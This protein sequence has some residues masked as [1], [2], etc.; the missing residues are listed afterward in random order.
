[1][2][3]HPAP[4]EAELWER[5]RRKQVGFKF[6]RQAILRHWIVDFW[7]PAKRLIVEVDGTSHLDPV[8]QFFDNFRDWCFEA[9]ANITTLRFPAEH[10]LKN[11]DAVALS[12]KTALAQ[13]RSRYISPRLMNTMTYHSQNPNGTGGN[14]TPFASNPRAKEH[15]EAALHAFEAF[16]P[17][18]IRNM[19]DLYGMRSGL[20]ELARALEGTAEQKRLLKHLRVLDRESEVIQQKI[21][22]RVEAERRSF[23]ERLEKNAPLCSHGHRMKIRKDKQHVPFW[24]CGEYPSCGSTKP[25]S[26]ADEVSYYAIA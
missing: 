26:P 15:A 7:C 20:A 25:L 10:V 4:G 3:A 23:L 2:R 13:R 22:E 6:R 19:R 12:I 14:A 1:M 16:K 17:S 24:G 18:R 8:R 5:L 11:T 21:H 9:K